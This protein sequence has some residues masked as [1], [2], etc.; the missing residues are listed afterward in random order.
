MVFLM[1]VFV[2][3]VGVVGGGG[4]DDGGGPSSRK[5]SNEGDQQLTAFTGCLRQ[6]LREVYAA[7]GYTC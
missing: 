6:A 1:L 2:L 7:T 3:G 4:C 5:L